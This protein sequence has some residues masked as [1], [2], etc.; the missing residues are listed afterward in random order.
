MSLFTLFGLSALLNI[1]MGARLLPD[2]AAIPAAQF[3][4]AAVLA[5][6]ALMMPLGLAARR[7]AR[8]ALS[9][10]LSRAGLL[11]MGLFSS[12]LVL[13]VARD[14]LLTL[15]RLADLLSPGVRTLVQW[16]SV[17]AQAVPV[18]A[19]V[20]TLLGYLNA[21]RTAAVV[22][23][24][25]PIAGL[26]AAWHGFAVAQISDVHVGPTI[27]QRYVR[28]IVDKVNALEADMVAITGDLVDGGRDRFRRRQLRGHAPQRPGGGLARRSGGCGSGAAGA[29]AAQRG[30]GV[31]SRL[32]PAAVGPHPRRAVLP[33]EPVRA[34]QQPFTAGLRKWEELWVYTS[35][36]RGYWGPP[37]RF[38][39][40]SEITY[41]R[42]VAA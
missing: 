25:V 26:P 11:C 13:T 6:C 2:L 31:Q 12:L 5:L 28:R 3:V 23:V 30:G 32:R 17:S 15:L 24:D 36:G 9:N 14:A 19:G 40:P 37:K 16:R 4:L 34:L 21:R 33:L 42:L 27:R 39:A 10:A 38:G 35:R 22:R 41:L 1:Y 29:P 8:P 20:V 18:L 7:I